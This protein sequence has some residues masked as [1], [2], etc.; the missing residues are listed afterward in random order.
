M[1]RACDSPLAY[2]PP[3]LPRMRAS[4]K[5]TPR[6][7]LFRGATTHKLVAMVVVTVMVEAK[8][9]RKLSVQPAA[10]ETAFSTEKKR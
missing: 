10:A 2:D 3:P 8:E 6:R 1:E 4:K 5:M 9:G 7:V